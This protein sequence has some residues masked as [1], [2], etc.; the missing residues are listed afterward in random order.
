LKKII[1]W[2]VK[3]E[4]IE[5]NPFV[6]FQLKFKRHERD[7]LQANEL[8][9]IED[10]DFDNSMLQKVKDLFIFSC[11][12]GLACIDV[13]ALKPEN[14][15]TNIDGTKWIRTSR[16]KT[17]TTVNVPLLKQALLILEHYITENEV[18]IRETI[19]PWISNQEVNRSL[20]IIAEV[21]N[22]K[23]HF[24]FHLARPPLLLR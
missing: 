4:W 22:I 7:F 9:A 6:G 16:A 12:T 13:T 15:I 23:K 5:K 2:A 17:D 10:H 18:M 1:T 8:A 14:I 19:F 11:Y 3:N 20:K 24:T 21:C